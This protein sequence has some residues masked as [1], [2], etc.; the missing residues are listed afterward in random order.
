[1][2]ADHCHPH[3]KMMKSIVIFYFPQHII[4]ILSRSILWGSICHLHSQVHDT[5]SFCNQSKQWLW[6]APVPSTG[7]SFFTPRSVQCQS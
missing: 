5:E 6:Y 4:P 2:V 7:S 3:P 1:M